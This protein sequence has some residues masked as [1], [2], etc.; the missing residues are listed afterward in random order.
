MPI[1]D[2]ALTAIVALLLLTVFKHPVMGAYVWAWLGLMNP[3]KLTYNF[4]FSLP[5]AQATAVVTLLALAG[6][7]KRQAVPMNGIV[8]TLL[9][10]LV[11]MT[12]TSF[13]A[14]NDANPVWDR[15]VFVMKIQVMLLV[16][17]M[18]VLDGKQLRTLIWVV[19]LS[20]G[21]FGFKGGIWTVMTGGSGRVWG[22]PGGMLE[23]NNQ[24]A[25]GLVM[26]MPFLYYLRQT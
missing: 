1:R 4:A 21:Y 8:V 22:P 25:V 15:W 20:V 17:W 13:F 10:L 6:T 14:L 16:T 12:V 3:H 23:D 11:W 24:L 18:L 2:F 5:F 19:V 9:V 7:R 26:L